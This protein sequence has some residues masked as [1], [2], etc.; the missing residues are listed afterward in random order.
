MTKHKHRPQKTRETG[1]ATAGSL[2]PAI[3]D[4]LSILVIY[5]VAVVVFREIILNNMAFSAQGDTIAALS[6][7]HAGRMLQEKEGTDVLWMPFFFSGMPTFGN[8]AFLPHD[9]N[10]V[11]TAVAK[12]LNLLFLNGTWTWYV[13]FYFLGGV[14]MFLL[15]RHLEF[16]RPV[17]LFAAMTFM[18]S[19]YTV[20]LAGEGHGSKL[21]ALVYLPLVFMLTDILFRRRDILSFGL[22]AASLG[23]LFLTNHLQI[24]YYALMVLGLFLLYRIILDV[25]Q[26]VLPVARGTVL[27]VA[28]LIIGFCIS[29]YVYLSVQEYAQYSMRGGG[30]TGAAGGLSWDYATN[31]SWH[32]SE[33]ITLLIPSYFGVPSMYWGNIIP[34]TN[35]TIYVGLLP[36]LFTVVALGYRRNSMTLF[37]GGLTLFA[38]LV[39]LGRNF[40]PL[41]ELLF[42]SLPFFNKFRVPSMILHLLPFLFG[43]LGAYG[44]AFLLKAG[45]QLKDMERQKLTKIFLVLLG[46]FVFLLAVT[47]VLK[48]WLFD[49]LSGSM[50]L[51]PGEPEQYR[52]QLGQQAPRAI[53]QLKQMRFDLFWKDLAKF[54]LLGSVAAGGTWML[55]RGKLRSG[56]YA[57]G[58]VIFVVVDLWVIS[59]RYLSPVAGKDIEAE[60]RPTATIN[61]LKQEPGLFR[62]FP[63]GQ[64]FMD[65]SY[66]YHGLQ[67][68]GGYSPAKLKIYQ[69]MLDSCLERGPSSALP[70]NLNILNMLNTAYLVVPGLLP[71]NPDFEQVSVDQTQ[72]L[73]VYRNRRVL[74]RAWYVR[75]TVVAS[76]DH[77]VFSALNA[78][79]F[80]PAQTAVLYTAPPIPI[81][82]QDSGSLPVITEYGA[83]RIV[84]KSET[85]SPALLVLS[86]VYYPAGWKAFIDGQETDILRT[87]YILRSVVVP[88]GSHEVV[89]SF[90]PPL[91]RIGWIIS[92]AAWV[93]AGLCILAGLWKLPAVRS[94][95]ARSP[96]EGDPKAG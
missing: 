72:R 3:R 82:P 37:L 65:N 55:L 63:V 51:K 91:Y 13:V 71:E 7:Q 2:S 84:M 12:I 62:I 75:G 60:L 17:A 64:T 48:S 96:G 47:V 33:F 76:N 49:T 24:V 70:W 79:S 83:R 43:I 94:R 21:M 59:S 46:G 69:T 92:N 54:A 29:S 57:A 30:T 8:M 39:A 15:I 85:V 95:L 45:E 78:T 44:L 86:E 6:Y 87:N 52:Q 73:V 25:K 32:P 11:Q 89:F 53:A 1:S 66:A 22:L 41:Y 38:F 61:F 80:D 26:G 18:L 27:F 19:P 28:A 88:A 90:D 67:S 81:A 9:V 31:W 34:W 23:T 20:G 68:I 4:L 5:L 74:P 58:V 42:V 35:S 36:I 16:P 40:A 56:I 77:E 93:I 14:F 10:Y 50:F